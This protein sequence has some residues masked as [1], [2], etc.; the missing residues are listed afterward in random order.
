[1]VHALQESWRVLA[2]NSYLIDL[3]PA[4]EHARIGLI[5]DGRF[6]IQWKTEES[7]EGSRAASRSLK[8]AEELR[9][10]RRGHSGRFSCTTV[11]PSTQHLKGWL[12]E[13]YGSESTDDADDLVKR[14]EDAIQVC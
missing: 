5:R 14:I 2:P 10:F 11:F 12:F 13:W 7:L 1:M 6:T 4:I 3:R 9:L 8:I